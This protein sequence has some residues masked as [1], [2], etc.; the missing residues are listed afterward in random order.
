[1]QT[2]TNDCPAP[3]PG[4]AHTPTL[5]K[6]QAIDLLLGEA[7]SLAGTETVAIDAGLGRILAEPLASPIA[8]PPWDNSA[9]DGYALSSAELGEGPTRLRVAQRIP[10]GTVGQPLAGGTAARIFTGA[11]VP[12]GAD[13][14][15][16]QEQCTREGDWVLV[17]TDLKPGA[18]I[19]RTGEDLEPGATVIAAGTRLRP[20]H[21]GLA[22]SVGT[23]HLHV[24]RRA[25]V[26]MF[27][28]GDEL[29]AP[30]QPL[31][32]GQIYN[33]NRFM[34]NGLLQGLGCE[35]IDLGVVPD[36]LDA[37]LEALRQGAEAADLILASGG[38]SVGEEDH[39]RPAIERLGTLHLWHVAVRPG[40]PLTFGRVLG[41][42]FIGAAGN[43]VA[44]FISVLIFMRP[45]LLRTQGVAGEVRPRGIRA[46]AG[47]DWSRPDRRREF[48]RGRWTRGADGEWEIQVH[49]S[50]SAAVLSAVA[51]ADGLVEIP[52]GRVIR[53]GDTVDFLSFDELLSS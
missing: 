31:A 2:H 53:R 18:N 44:L 19:R 17:P 3:R 26:A 28:T 40:K 5:T 33:S 16:I 4:E 52:E 11:P 36:S 22:A 32:P 48:A 41:T 25:R 10:A 34:L 12:A 14:V 37:T 23:T 49:P 45:F 13:T 9:M 29:I 43:P 38:V 50:R 42:P 15:V 24:Y 46:R 1:M 21:L 35:I 39:V 7:R 6:D 20:H 51:W 8:V 47:F 27:S 30:G